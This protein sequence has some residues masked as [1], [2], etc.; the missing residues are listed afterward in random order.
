[1]NY[2]IYEEQTGKIVRHVGCPDQY[3][4]SQCQVGEKF[5]GPLSSIDDS[6]T[7]VADGG[8]VI[9]P[10]TRRELSL[11]KIRETRNVLIV[12]TDWTQLSDVALDPDRRAAWAAYRQE[13]RDFPATCDPYNPSWPVPPA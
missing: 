7:H 12:A 11:R 8:P 9:D 13:L 10:E 1:M 3:I 2:L 6:W 5:F 4:E